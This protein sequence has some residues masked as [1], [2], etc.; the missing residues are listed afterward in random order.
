MAC[1]FI[2]K[3]DGRLVIEVWLVCMIVCHARLVKHLASDP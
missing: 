2:H 1:G 3:V